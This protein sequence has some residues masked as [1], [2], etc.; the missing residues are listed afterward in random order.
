VA[1]STVA[2]PVPE[3]EREGLTSLE[4]VPVGG[5]TLRAVIWMET[6]HPPIPQFVLERSASERKP[7]GVHVDTPVAGIR[8]PE[9]RGRAV[10][11]VLRPADLN[12]LSVTQPGF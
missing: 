4:V 9:H 6:R 8:S 2:V 12:L 5:E 11:S 10:D 1:I 7:A 3:S